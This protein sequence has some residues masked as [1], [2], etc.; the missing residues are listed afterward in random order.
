MLFDGERLKPSHRS[1]VVLALYLPD[2]FD[3]PS[4]AAKPSSL[5]P[6]ARQHAMATRFQFSQ[7]R[8]SLGIAAIAAAT[9]AGSASGSSL[10]A[11]PSPPS[12]CM[13]SAISQSGGLA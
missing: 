8:S 10:D 3:Q 7:S 13:A 9:I 4:K 12:S 5:P 6:V 2:L 1:R 11:R